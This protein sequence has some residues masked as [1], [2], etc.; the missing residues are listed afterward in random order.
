MSPLAT[1][2]RARGLLRLQKLK[3]ALNL[4]GEGATAC[5][6]KPEEEGALTGTATPPSPSASEE[7]DVSVFVEETLV[8]VADMPAPVGRKS[9]VARP[10][11]PASLACVSSESEL[12][13]YSLEALKKLAKSSSVDLPKQA[14]KPIVLGLLVDTLR[15]RRCDGSSEE[16]SAAEA[17]P[18]AAAAACGGGDLLR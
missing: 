10:P 14:T 8:R 17:T 13:K 5:H 16:G 12:L 11:P 15:S 4:E 3:L 2:F 1:D 9:A 7:R 18:L 6:E